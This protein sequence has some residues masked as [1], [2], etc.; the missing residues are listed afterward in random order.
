MCTVFLCLS[1]ILRDSEKTVSLT[2]PYL[3]DHTPFAAQ[4][5]N[6]HLL[7]WIESDSF[8]ILHM[9]I[10][11]SSQQQMRFPAEGLTYVPDLKFWAL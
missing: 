2:F 5:S 1:L 10:Q 6:N 9:D 3:S 7:L 8:S 11:Y 4:V